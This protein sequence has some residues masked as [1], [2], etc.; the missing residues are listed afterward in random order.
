MNKNRELSGDSFRHLTSLRRALHRIPE[1]SG[2]EAETARRI[3][4]EL[5]ACKPDE[6]IT[7][8]GGNGILATYKAASGTP[9]QTL[10]F[11]A[12]LDAVAVTEET[13]LPYH[14]ENRGTMHA[15]GH[16]GHMAILIGLA[17]LLSDTRATDLDLLLLFQPAE[18]T[19][20]G[21][22]ALLKDPR[23]HSLT[24]DHGFAL[25]NLP[26]YEEN[27][28]YI[29]E[30]SFASASVG[31]E[32]TLKG[33][34]SHA[35]YPE[36]GLNP[37]YFLSELILDLRNQLQDF[38]NA[39]PGNKMAVTYIRMGERA[40]GISPGEAVLGITLRS[41]TDK[42]L[43]AGINTCELRICNLAKRFEGEITHKKVEPFSSVMNSAEGVQRVKKAA[44]M[45]GLR[46]EELSHP[47]PWS[48]D[49]GEF[50]RQFP[51]TLFG[52]GAGPHHPPL[53]SEMYDFNENL[54]R[55]GV[56][57]F[58]NIIASFE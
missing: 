38:V 55:R 8:M 51:L 32:V 57:I 1:R 31:L 14:S 48:E 33:R 4:E 18:E 53:H 37:S 44:E 42:G 49:F 35:A 22:A 28:I 50:R 26:G 6:M 9:K 34:F 54:I 16:D 5:A 36:Q 10:L 45:S 11:R 58:S 17:H 30:N 15:C 27:T 25:H 21:A 52:L 19:G 43:R 23:F 7:G 39:D 3:E 24:I 47:F 12:E 29:K 20:E 46:V 56:E 13:R 41:A 40:F 2:G